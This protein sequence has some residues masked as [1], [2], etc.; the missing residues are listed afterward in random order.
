MRYFEI[1]REEEMNWAASGKFWHNTKTGET[2]RVRGHHTLVAFKIPEIAQFLKSVMGSEFEDFE[3]RIFT[4]AD[5]FFKNDRDDSNAPYLEMHDKVC[6]IL[7]NAGYL[8]G[9]HDLV[10]DIQFN[11]RYERPCR[12]FVAMILPYG[13]VAVNFDIIDWNKSIQLDKAEA[14][15]FVRGRSLKAFR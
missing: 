11:S 13:S 7:C 6:E 2:F 8:R 14:D 15:M 10:L 4:A 9:N 12:E 5:S 1:I 3:K